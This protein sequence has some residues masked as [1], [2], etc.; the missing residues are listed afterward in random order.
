MID[1]TTAW[2]H[3][4]STI[5]GFLRRRLA[6][7]ADAEDLLQETFLR[8]YRADPPGLAD[9]SAVRAWLLRT[10][11]NLLTDHYR[12]ARPIVTLEDDP[13]DEGHRLPTP[14][15]SL[16]PC[17][18]SLVSRLPEKYRQA[19]ALDLEGV[20]QREI[21]KREGVGLSGAKSRVQRARNLLRG[22]FERCCTFTHDEDGSLLDYRIRREQRPCA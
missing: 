18:T 21:A 22:E 17:I 3:H 1:I 2:K 9:S 12:A 5:S 10:A 15:E 19:L 13:A 16:E 4:Q 11:R 8:L 20:P 7:P 6:N 14:L